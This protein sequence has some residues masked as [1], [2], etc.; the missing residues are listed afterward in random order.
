[1]LV[2]PPEQH[3]Y[4]SII[5]LETWLHFHCLS[6]HGVFVVSNEVSVMLCLLFEYLSFCAISKM[7]FWSSETKKCLLFSFQ[8]F[9][10]NK[11]QS[12]NQIK[13]GKM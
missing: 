8:I 3:S 10:K 1:M 9:E 6:H 13:C 12:N 5:M 11:K 2:L 4:V 7:I